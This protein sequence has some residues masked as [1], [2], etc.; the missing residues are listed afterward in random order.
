[1]NRR[2]GVISFVGSLLAL[3]LSL[4]ACT[5]QPP[6][7]PYPPVVVAQE[8]HD[9]PVNVQLFGFFFSKN[10]K[11]TISFIGIPTTSGVQDLNNHLAKNPPSQPTTDGSGTFVYSFTPECVTHDSSYDNSTDLVHV[12]AVDDKTFYG[13]AT[14]VHAKDWYCPAPPPPPPPP[15]PHHGGGHGGGPGKK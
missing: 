10:A 14:T 4:V 2:L 6:Q 15:P 5:S 11:V 3:A 12:L 7:P 8:S 9:S 13:G 1:M